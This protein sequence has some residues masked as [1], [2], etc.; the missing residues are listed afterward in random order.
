MIIGAIRL[1]RT[2]RCGRLIGNIFG[3][4]GA[5]AC[6]HGWS[7][8]RPK[9]GE[10]NPWTMNSFLNPAPEGQRNRVASHI[11]TATPRRRLPLPPRSGDG[12]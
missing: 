9:P 4:K 11:R 6:S 8:A 1:L 12:K 10:R 5:A 3:P 7:K 2:K